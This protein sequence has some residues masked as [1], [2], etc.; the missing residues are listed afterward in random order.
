MRPEYACMVATEERKV[1][2]RQES[3]L[4][5]AVLKSEGRSCMIWT[6]V[7]IGAQTDLDLISRGD[8]VQGRRY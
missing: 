5:I 4:Q 7:S 1:Y 3:G 8:R 2:R 6:A